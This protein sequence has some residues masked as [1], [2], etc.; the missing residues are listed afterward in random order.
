MFFYVLLHSH[1]WFIAGALGKPLE[2]YE[3]D[4]EELDL[5]AE[6]EDIDIVPE[7]DSLGITMGDVRI[8]ALDS[9]EVS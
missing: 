5:E 8:I 9:T 4:E 7:D 3:D 1:T 6:M 2:E